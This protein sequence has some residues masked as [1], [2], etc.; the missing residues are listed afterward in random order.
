MQNV[1]DVT[2]GRVYLPLILFGPADKQELFPG[3]DELGVE[4]RL[5]ASPRQAARNTPTT[6][7][8]F[9]PIEAVA[10]QTSQRL[11]AGRTMG[12]S[13]LH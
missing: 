11:S 7:T 12:A 2:T 1:P 10:Y 8:A 5:A 4:T 13:P 6:N 9:L 3:Q